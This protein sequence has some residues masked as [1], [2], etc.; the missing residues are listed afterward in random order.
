MNKLLLTTGIMEIIAGTMIAG[1]GFAII[2]KCDDNPIDSKGDVI[3]KAGVG[4]CMCGAGGYI[5]GGGLR[6]IC[7]SKIKTS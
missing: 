6:D 2:S 1:Y 4:T 5:M 3:L 7:L